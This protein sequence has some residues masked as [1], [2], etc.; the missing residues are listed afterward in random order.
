MTRERNRRVFFSAGVGIIQRF[1]Q[2]FGI[3]LTMP[4][5]LH[6]LGQQRFGVWS[7]VTSLSW[8]SGLADFGI[9]YVMV[10]LV[11]KAVGLGHIDQARE[12]IGAGLKLGAFLAV[13]IF[14]ISSVAVVGIAPTEEVFPYLVAIVALAVTVPLG[15]ANSVWMALQKG[16]IAGGWEMAQTVLTIGGI[17]TASVMSTDVL[18]YVVIVSAGSIA[19]NLGSLIHLFIRHPELR[20]LGLAVPMGLLRTLADRS[21]PFFIL[22][23][24]NTLAVFSD[25]ILALELLGTD[26]SAQMAI[27]LRICMTAMALLV[28]FSQPLLPAFTDAIAK[29][30]KRWVRR[31][32]VRGTVLTVGAALMGSSILVLFGEPLL[33]W[34]LRSDLK[35]AA[36]LYWAMAAWIVGFSL[37]R[38]PA[39]LLNAEWVIKSQLLVAAIYGITAF[40][41]KIVLAPSYGVSGILW[42]TAFANLFVV[43]P[44]YAYL[45]Y[46]RRQLWQSQTCLP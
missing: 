18:I 43:A 41:L 31:G 42:G 46:R 3:L 23:I 11:A 7:A 38:V 1:F 26:A 35:F 8:L 44:A 29:G 27:A 17:V 37:A 9:S 6:A 15:I 24:V 21:V 30:D 5:V 14:M 4:L 13:L 2:L 10:M 33:L 39:L 45:F 19:A 25:N 40:G 20:P 28:V 32:L 12:Y 34:W 36:S 22:G 16:Y